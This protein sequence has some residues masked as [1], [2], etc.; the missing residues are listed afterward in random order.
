MAKVEGDCG[1]GRKSDSSTQDI[2]QN[3]H[4]MLITNDK[5]RRRLKLDLSS[6]QVLRLFALPFV[7]DVLGYGERLA[8]SALVIR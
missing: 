8:G 7:G 4:S 5:E 3:L 2:F 1:L 6:H